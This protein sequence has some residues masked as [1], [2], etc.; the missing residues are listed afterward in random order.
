MMDSVLTPALALIAWTFVIAAWMYATRIPAMRKARINPA[1]MKE[2]SEL[3][4]LPRPVRQIAENYN[5][6]H[7][8][9]VVFY[10]LVFYSHLAGNTGAWMIGLAWV[11]VA[12]R[13]AHSLVQCTTNF[14]PLRFFIFI[15]AS[16]ALVAMTAINVAAL[17]V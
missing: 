15:G 10:A 7:E 13:I 1:K 8:Q 11:Y 2:K 3:D 12:A 4:V 9:P 14:I 16:L 6:L 5:H 17:M